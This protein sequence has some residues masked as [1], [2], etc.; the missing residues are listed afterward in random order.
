MRIDRAEIRSLEVPLRSGFETSFGRVAHREPVIVTLFS[1]GLR[2]YGEAPVAARP[3][4]SAETTATAAHVLRD[5]LVPA[6][7]GREIPDVEAL[8]RTIAWV[9]GHHMARA[10]LEAAFR[11]LEA[12]AAGVSLAA[13]YGATAAEVEVGVSLGIPE[14]GPR[15]GA[16]ALLSEVERRVAEGYRRVKVKIKPGFDIGPLEHVRARFPDLPLA[17]DGNGAYAES[18]APRLAGLGRYW[19][20]FLE[21]P[22]SPDDLCAHARLAKG[23]GVA[24]CLDESLPSVG[25]LETAIAL[26][27]CSV[28]N[29]KPGRTGGPG[30]ALAMARLAA[31]RGLRA[32]LGGML[33][34]GIGRA[35]N[36]A[37]AG[38]APFTMPGDL[39]ASDR[40]WEEDIVEPAFRLLPGGRLA[41][42]RGPGIGVEVIEERLA[43]VTTAVETLVPQTEGA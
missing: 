5:F 9:R 39:S 26:G 35:H 34:T 4:Y 6:V 21:Q 12:K 36:V 43:R 3:H 24:V 28:V 18:D 8:L 7:L 37:L 40:Y 41:V 2:G 11:D 15:G 14:P 17:A 31:A 19:L 16:A 13:A 27:S 42:P 20:L 1:G 38:C 10:A 29:V 33:E 25:V 30:A 22:F 32:W 23:S